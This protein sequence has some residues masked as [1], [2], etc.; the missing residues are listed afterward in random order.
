MSPLLPLLALTIRDPQV[1]LPKLRPML[2]WAGMERLKQR[3]NTAKAWAPENFGALGIDPKAPIKAMVPALDGPL[4]VELAIADPNQVDRAIATKP[5]RGMT[6]A[7]TDRRLVVQEP[8]PNA[9]ALQRPTKGKAPLTLEVNDWEAIEHALVEVE[10]QPR[11]IEAKGTASLTLAANLIANDLL[12]DRPARR[13]LA[14]LGAVIELS[15]TAGAGAFREA[16]IEAGMTTEE[17]DRARKL[18]S[19]EHAVALTKDGQLA[20]V[21][22]LSGS[23]AKKDVAAFIARMIALQPGLQIREIGDGFLLGWFPGA[24]PKASPALGKEIAEAPHAE[25]AI[26]LRV[27]PRALINALR[28]RARTRIGPAVHG[29]QLTIFEALYENVLRKAKSARFTA[30]RVRGEIQAT[31]TIEH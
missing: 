15:G 16:L 29:A 11:R 8:F 3:A 6:L 17:A 12:A 28:K 9:E 2:E 19:G 26:D 1:D 22:R 23:A 4:I 21:V 24:D 14:S 18:L 27:D 30:S 5:I 13:Y 7:R 25:T 31:A 10:L 20:G